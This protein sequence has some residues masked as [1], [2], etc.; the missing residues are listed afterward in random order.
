MLL[1]SGQ[2]EFQ[3]QGINN[4][5]SEICIS[6]TQGDMEIFSNPS[7]IDPDNDPNNVLIS[8]ESCICLN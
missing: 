1:Q 5:I 7:G 6:L 2:T 3:H 8:S 4:L